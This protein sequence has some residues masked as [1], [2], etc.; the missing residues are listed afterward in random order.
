MYLEAVI[1]GYKRPNAPYNEE[2]RKKLEDKIHEELV[3]ILSSLQKLH[4][5]TDILDRNR[6]VKAIEIATWH[7]EHPE[8][9]NG[10]LKINTKIFGIHN[11]REIIREKIT[12]RLKER[13]ENGMI[14]E[15]EILLGKR[16]RV[17]NRVTH[18][19]TPE[20]LKSYGLEY[21]FITQYI[22]GEINKDDMFQKLNTAIHRFAKRQ[23]TWFRRMERNG[24]KINWINGDLSLPKKVDEIIKSLNSKESIYAK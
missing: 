17:L 18:K 13:L 5:T 4:N 10:I 22:L 11:D 1:K 3:K 2:L 16:S 8:T 24:I 6:L 15:V 19:V 12:K 7:K 9:T 14:E 21:K 23:M 20:K